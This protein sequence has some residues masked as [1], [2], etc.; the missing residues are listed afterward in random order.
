MAVELIAK[1]KQINGGT[2]KLVDAVDVEMEDGR[3]LQTTID[4]IGT[5][6]GG[7]SL[8]CVHEG[9]PTETQIKKNEIFIDKSPD[10]SMQGAANNISTLFMDEIRSMFQSLKNT[11]TDQQRRILELEARVRYLESLHATIPDSTDDLLM[12][13]EDGFVLINEN[14]QILCFNDATSTVITA[15]LMTNE[16]GSILINEDGNIL[17]FDVTSSTITT[18]QLLVNEN[19]DILINEDG[20]ILCLDTSTKTSENTEIMVNENNNILVNENGDVLC[21]KVV[22]ETG[23]TKIF[24][25][26]NDQCLVNE[27]GDVLCLD[28]YNM[29]LVNENGETL[30]NDNDNILK[31]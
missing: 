8:I 9:E 14:N 31:L 23:V 25:N 12:T 1:I 6:G 30:T 24:V 11:I 29:I 5:S 21:F 15:Q 16:D 22:D 2:F 10:A 19:G 26:E 27:N 18:D 20:H 28:V 4:E 3:D 13:N 7:Q 17:C